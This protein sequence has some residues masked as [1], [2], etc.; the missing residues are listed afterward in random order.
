MISDINNLWTESWNACK[1]DIDLTNARVGG[2]ATKALP[3][4]EDI[5][6]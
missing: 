1:G 3:D 4:K 2:R 6:F 5:N